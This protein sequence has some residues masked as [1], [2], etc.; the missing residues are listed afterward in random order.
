MRYGYLCDACGSEPEVSCP[1]G[2]A[3]AEVACPCGAQ[4]HQT[5]NANVQ[6]IIRGNQRMFDVDNLNNRPIG[7]E[8]GN[9]AE[10]QNR[11]Y[12]KITA[13]AK[14]AARKVDKQAIKGG[15]RLIA[16]VPRELHRARSN[17]FGKDYFDPSK[18][19]GAEMKQKL[20]EDGL[21]LHKD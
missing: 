8:W 17:Q 18:Q 14:K 13:D 10:A 15:I 12:S 16:K 6:C 7:W 21:Y 5:F 20:K 4:A 19:S 2:Q 9:T 1:M 3:P 11:R